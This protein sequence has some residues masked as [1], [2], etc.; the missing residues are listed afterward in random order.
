VTDR[1]HLIGLDFETSGT[2]HEESAPI[3]IGLA[4]RDGEV[5]VSL[6]GGWKWLGEWR[7]MEKAYEWNERSFEI[8]RI[9]RDRLASAPP[10]AEVDRE[11]ARFVTSSYK[12]VRS[13]WVV[14]VGWNVA[15]FDLP[16]LRKHFPKTQ[17]NMSY[18][19]IDL[20]AIVFAV[21][22]SG[23][24]RPTGE[25]WTY[26]ALKGFVKNA[27]AERVAAE[28]DFFDGAEWHDAGYDALASLYAYDALRGV[29]RTSGRPA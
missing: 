12:G 19:S 29:L 5:M 11:A 10:A 28:S 23:L 16:F 6:V 24:T 13:N 20:N 2:D 25:A 1:P 17:R 26:K 8:H 18:R 15:G 4:N 27:A 3:Q 21:T 22:E 14:A 9:E 7:G